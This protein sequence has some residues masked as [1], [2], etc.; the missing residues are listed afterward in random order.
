MTSTAPGIRPRLE[1]WLPALAFL[2]DI[3]MAGIAFVAA[4]YL[5]VGSEAFTTYRAALEGG[6]PIFMATSASS[7]Q[8]LQL[9]RGLWRYASLRDLAALVKA[10]TLAV[11]IFIPAIF[12]LNRMTLLPRSAPLIAWFVLVALLPGQRLLYRSLKDRVAGQRAEAAL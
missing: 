1:R 2:H 8:I 12:L 9:Y 3:V 7:F 5:R 6:L 11:L 10:T 4:M